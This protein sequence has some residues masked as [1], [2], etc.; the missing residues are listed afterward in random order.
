[1]L[2]S[3]TSHDRIS[4]NIPSFCIIIQIFINNFEKI[5]ILNFGISYVR[6]WEGTD[7]C[8]TYTTYMPL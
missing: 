3:S 7:H 4:I 8:L 5:I 1:M 2:E 6:T